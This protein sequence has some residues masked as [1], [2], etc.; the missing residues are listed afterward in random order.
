[1]TKLHKDGYLGSFDWES[2]EQCESCLLGKMAKS[3]FS[4]KDEQATECLRL[5]HSDDCGPINI[6]SIG[7]FSYFITFTNDHSRYD[8]MYLM[9]FKFETFEKFKEFKN[10][11]KK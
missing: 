1:M 2:F 9:K 11:V 5:I 7:G 6:Q 3:P 8:Y 10:K 4:K